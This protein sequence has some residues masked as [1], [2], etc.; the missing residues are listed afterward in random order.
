MSIPV[1]GGPQRCCIAALC[2]SGFNDNFR[3]KLLDHQKKQDGIMIAKCE[4]KQARSGDK[5]EVMLSKQS[6]I[7]DCTD[8]FDISTV[9]DKIS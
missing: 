1:H 4:I 8:T 3:Q 7:S 5:L 2:L 6:E 9:E